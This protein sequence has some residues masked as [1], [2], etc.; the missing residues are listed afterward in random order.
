MTKR[1]AWFTGEPTIKE[2][3]TPYKV[4][5]VVLEGVKSFNVINDKGG[6][7]N[8]LKKGC[9]HICHGDWVFADV[10]EEE[11][12]KRKGVVAL[13]PEDSEFKIGQEVEV[14]DSALYKGLAI[15]KG[16]DYS[17]NPYGYI[18]ETSENVGASPYHNGLCKDGHALWV[19]EGGIKA[20]PTKTK[21]TK[22]WSD[23]I[24][25]TTGKCPEDLKRGQKIKLKWS[26]GDEFNITDSQDGDWYIDRGDGAVNITHYK[27]KIKDQLLDKQEKPESKWTKNTGVRPV[28]GNI[29]V[30]MKF[31]DGTIAK[32]QAQRYCWDLGQSRKIIKWRLAE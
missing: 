11:P 16:Y 5:E 31:S 28:E 27:V 13:L 1:V 32:K 15:I 4:Y 20:A 24:E 19:R 3:F 25:N 22:K 30:M 12:I 2:C 14:V 17:G 7:N 21:K 8:C 9:A 29:T 10:V 18:L 23:W 6:Q 26:D